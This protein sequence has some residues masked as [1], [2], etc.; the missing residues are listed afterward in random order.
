M[1]CSLCGF[2]YSE[3]EVQTA[4]SACPVTK[5]C[6]LLRCPNC[7]YE[8]PPEPKWLKT[9]RGWFS[10]RGQRPFS[11]SKNHGEGREKGRCPLF[12][13]AVNQESE[14]TSIQTNDSK[15]LQKL[16][17]IGLFP[18]T[19]LTLIQK[20]PSYTFQMGHSQFVIDRELAECIYCKIMPIDQA[21]L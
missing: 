20:F 9:I 21:F 17:A 7:G 3:Q 6:Q 1:K 2:H 8:T 16:I 13:L 11:Q 18:G 15:K 4:C 19:K 5:G 12:L 10:K 14:V